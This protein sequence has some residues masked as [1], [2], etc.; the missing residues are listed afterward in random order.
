MKTKVIIE[1]DDETRD[2][3]I[4]ATHGDEKIKRDLAAKHTRA[5]MQSLLSALNKVAD[6]LCDK[7]S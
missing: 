1:I 5:V 4:T 2:S 3:V 7:D 6:E